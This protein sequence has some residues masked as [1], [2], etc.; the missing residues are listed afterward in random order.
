MKNMNRFHKGSIVIQV[1]AF[2]SIGIVIISGFVKWG[3]GSVRLARQAEQKEQALQIAEAGIDYYRWHLAHDAADFQD[4]TGAAGPYL[5]PF[6]DKSGVQIGQYALTISQPTLGSSIVNITSTGTVL[7]NP[8]ISRAVK[9]R[10]GKPSFAKYAAI[11]NSDLYIGANIQG[12]M[13]SNGMINLVTDSA[14]NIVTSSKTKGTTTWATSP[15]KWAVWG[16]GD[17]N[18]PTP[19][20]T[21]TATF[22]GG[23]DIGV[24]ALDFAGITVNLT[25]MKAATVAPHLYP[26][27]GVSGYH[28]VLKTTGVYDIYKVNTIVATPGGAG[29]NSKE[30]WN[31]SGACANKPNTSW[32]IATET[33]LPGATGLNVPFPSNGLIFVEDNLWIDGTINGAR[34]TFVA[35]NVGSTPLRNIIVNN[36][37]RYTNYDGT[38]VIGLI[39]QDNFWVGLKGGETLRIDAAI[40]AQT[41][42]VS[43]MLY[44]GCGTD[45][46]KND[47]YFYG[48]WATNKRYQYG[49]L[50]SAAAGNCGGVASGYNGNRT[51]EYDGNLLYGP[52]PYFPATADNYQ[53]ITWDE[54]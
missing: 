47:I 32:S 22:L 46:V 48:M 36:N 3:M 17:P 51:Y 10:V 27:S 21:T 29:C 35:A 52:P 11:S 9:V 42:R 28:I 15:T 16:S 6:Y 39:A 38:D 4:G 49:F 40:L 53:I 37:L 14:D 50:N 43:R 1:L 26:A 13:H 34:L 18:W 23:R 19:L 8:S 44:Q 54:I 33:I 12:P 20:T 24:P 45:D 31:T 25:T 7:A 30:W 2:M 41:G 5:H